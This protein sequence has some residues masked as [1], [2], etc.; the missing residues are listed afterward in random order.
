MVIGEY[1]VTDSLLAYASHNLERYQV[2]ILNHWQR[3]RKSKTWLLAAM[4]LLAL[5]IWPL[6]IV[7]PEGFCMT[8]FNDEEFV[9]GQCPVPPSNVNE[10]LKAYV[11]DE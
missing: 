6:L 3:L 4:T 5:A 8:R 9:M 10:M 11:Y 1:L 7:I 2:D